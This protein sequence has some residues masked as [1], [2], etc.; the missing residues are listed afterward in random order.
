VALASP[1]L[2]GAGDTLL[3]DAPGDPVRA[4]IATSTPGAIDA[5]NQRQPIVLTLKS[6]LGR[7]VTWNA[8]QVQTSRLVH[9]E[10]FIVVPG[11][12]SAELRFFPNFEP[13]PVLTNPANYTVVSN[14][15]GIQAGE[16]QPFSIADEAGD[17]FVR[18][19]LHERSTELGGYLAGKQ[20]REFNTFVRINA[21][22]PSRLR[23]KK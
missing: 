9:R 7:A 22:L 18:A 17:K 11:V 16:T 23:P 10:A 4:I 19:S 12:A 5:T 6:P 8:S 1:P 13:L 20:Q 21:A 2:P 14:Q 15:L 3:I